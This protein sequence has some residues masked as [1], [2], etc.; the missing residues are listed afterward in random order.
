MTDNF[1]SSDE[2]RKKI[3]EFCKM[4]WNMQK[5]ITGLSQDLIKIISSDDIKA[6]ISFFLDA[7]GNSQAYPAKPILTYISSFLLEDPASVFAN[8][9][10]NNPNHVAGA[11]K[12]IQEYGVSM[13]NK[14]P[15]YSEV[16]ANCALNVL[17]LALTGNSHTEIKNCIF[18]IS[19]STY[20][21]VLVASGRLF[22]PE[23]FNK[24]RQLFKSADP[25]DGQTSQLP[26]TQSHLPIALFSD[27][28][29]DPHFNDCYK[30]TFHMYLYSLHI[31]FEESCSL[32]TERL[33]SGIF[34]YLVNLYFRKPL[35]FLQYFIDLFIKSNDQ[36]LS[37]L[38]QSLFS[39]KTSN[40]NWEAIGI[41]HE[42]V[43]DQF[44]NG[45]L[46]TYESAYSFFTEKPDLSQIPLESLIKESLKYPAFIDDLSSTYKN[47]L[48]FQGNEDI[49]ERENRIA[50]LIILTKQL[51]KVYHDI[52]MTWSFQNYLNEILYWLY[53]NLMI[54]DTS[55]QQDKFEILY[56]FFISLV[57]DATKLGDNNKKMELQSVFDKFE[58]PFRSFAYNFLNSTEVVTSQISEYGI[59]QFGN[60]SGFIHMIANFLNKC[61]NNNDVEIDII[62]KNPILFPSAFLWA[63]KSLH[64]NASK[65]FR[66]K[67]PHY[68][69]L[70]IMFFRFAACLQHNP[71]IMIKDMNYDIMMRFPPQN[72]DNLRHIILTQLSKL[73]THFDLSEDIIQTIF[74]SWR[75]WAETLSIEKFVRIILDVLLWNES[76]SNNELESR[77][78]F[79]Y[80]GS[81]LSIIF[82]Q[83]IELLQRIFDTVLSFIYEYDGPVNDG[84]NVASFTV[85]I[86]RSM[87]DKLNET[88]D[89]FFEFQR[90]VKNESSIKSLKF[91]FTSHFLLI[92]LCVPY[93]QNMISIDMF[94]KD[95]LEF[96]WE[97]GIDFFIIQSQNKAK[98]QVEEPFI[99]PLSF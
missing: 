47:Y 66:L 50:K 49:H 97:A 60:T 74:F 7:L 75:A 59:Y 78:L 79:Q 2:N 42:I 96:N 72:P 10:L 70:K 30:H 23:K 14:L 76:C 71:F 69:I 55:Q 91:S 45:I 56:I 27:I 12:I 40:Y 3:T 8:L 53:S 5:P 35:F 16:S 63:T 38:L 57:D 36:T 44:P 65:L 25:F 80:A 31:K 29:Y 28:V 88:F 4:Y 22:A 77:H 34:I 51:L 41:S 83:N 37:D 33:K 54:L 94:D 98:T 46:P 67:I 13:F 89:K 81:S 84:Y 18:K 87:K 32:I 15:V 48:Q 95:F 73:S 64:P 93:L 17:Y 1:F 6:I 24:V 9:D 99:D 85:L 68:K 52:R 11:R 43:Q 82:Y 19:T 90:R 86:M 58:E 62:E 26:L 20:F 61:Q 92:S 21:S 39:K